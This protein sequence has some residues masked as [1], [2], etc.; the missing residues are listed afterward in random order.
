MAGDS[1]SGFKSG[2]ACMQKFR[3][4]LLKVVKIVQLGQQKKWAT[5]HFLLSR[6]KLAKI[7]VT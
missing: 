4:G 3:V 2:A 7:E 5:A 6:G 1:V